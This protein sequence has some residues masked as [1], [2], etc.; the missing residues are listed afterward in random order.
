MYEL[1]R[2]E[3]LLPDEG[4][5]PK[6]LV[7]GR[8]KNKEL[9][10]FSGDYIPNFYVGKDEKVDLD[11]RYVKDVSKEIY[12]SLDG[13]DVKKIFVKCSPLARLTTIMNELREPFKDTYESHILLSRRAIIDWGIMNSFTVKDKQLIPTE[14]KLSITPRTIY[15]DIEINLAPE[16][17][18][19]VDNP[20]H[21]IV[22]LSFYDN[23]TNKLIAMAWHPSFKEEI[24][25]KNISIDT[26]YGVDKFEVIVHKFTN[27]R[28]LLNSFLEYVS[29]TDPDII[30]GWFAVG[31]F[32]KK[33]H[34]WAQGFDMPYIINRLSKLGLNRNR[35]SPIN[36]S[37]VTKDKRSIVKGR[38]LFELQEAYRVLQR[39][40]K[41]LES[42][43][44]SFVTKH[45]LK[46]KGITPNKK[47]FIEK[48]WKESPIELLQLNVL[49]VVGIVLLD[50]YKQV[51]SRWDEIRKITGCY[52]DDV[53]MYSRVVH[54]LAL[55]F[56]KGKYILPDKLTKEEIYS[57]FV[58]AYVKE[59]KIGVHNWII[60]FDFRTL[61]P[62]ILRHFN[63]SPETIDDNG[64]IKVDCKLRLKETNEVVDKT[65]CYKQEP[66]G[67]FPTIVDYLIQERFLTKKRLREATNETERELYYIQDRAYKFLLNSVYGVLGSKYYSLYNPFVGACIASVA[68]RF[69]EYI[70]NMLKVLGYEV[71]YADTDGIY[72]ISGFKDLE[73]SIELAHKLH[74]SLSEAL[75][76]FVATE[77]K[78]DKTF[79]IGRP[80]I[81]RSIF[82]KQV[83]E[84][85]KVKGKVI[86]KARGAKKA[87][88]ARLVYEDDKK[89]NRLI[90]KGLETGKSDSSPYSKKAQLVLLE[91]V[92]DNAP[93]EKLIEFTRQ[94]INDYGIKSG[95][96]DISVPKGI[97]SP[98]ASYKRPTAV[99]RGASYCNR[100][101]HTDIKSGSKPR[102][103]YIDYVI[104]YTPTDVIAF[105]DLSLLPIDKIKVNYGKMFEK[106]VRHKLECVLEAVGIDWIQEGFPVYKPPKRVKIW[107]AIRDFK[108]KQ[109]M[110]TDYK[111]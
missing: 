72:V 28:S 51:I 3:Y 22:C 24:E 60:E 43:S 81:Y 44:L 57:K 110:L 79:E 73:S 68:R 48:M 90:I 99:V 95:L 100:Y 31:Y 93:R 104:G 19:S 101:F 105:E 10:L 23:Y 25:I 49:D 65:I 33:L 91:M 75:N 59:P 86:R 89:V 92:L 111:K 67:L 69:I 41:E 34:K 20:I 32:N 87:F 71:V 76:K 39:A 77:W 58:G 47:A 15:L 38:I 109:C 2:L 4:T 12:K 1:M 94:V 40:D 63:M 80:S 103:V 88:G 66:K 55:R 5:I 54:I 85:L 61:Y 82:F 27:E 106:T 83:R 11:W 78:I 18:M 29:D 98:F 107:K 6:I 14:E 62:D 45:E 7:W 108:G 13:K 16:D 102:Y 37:Y 50:K 56:S 53:L 74:T 46:M 96:M 8:D 64:E 26:K 84:K 36:Q 70:E 42:W 30:T 97:S 21:S 52:L 9:H 17:S 35:L